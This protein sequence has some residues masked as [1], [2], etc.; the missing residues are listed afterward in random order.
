MLAGRDSARPVPCRTGLRRKKEITTERAWD[1]V[2]GLVEQL[3]HAWASSKG[4]ISR[5][6][7]LIPLRMAVGLPTDTVPKRPDTWITVRKNWACW[8]TPNGETDPDKADVWIAPLDLHGQPE[9]S[10]AI[11][12][13]AVTHWES[14]GWLGRQPS[15]QDLRQLAAQA[16]A[17][18]GTFSREADQPDPLTEGAEKIRAHITSLAEKAEAVDNDHLNVEYEDGARG[19]LGG[20]FGDYAGRFNPDVAGYLSDL[21]V[22][23]AT[24]QSAAA[25]RAIVEKIAAAYNDAATRDQHRTYSY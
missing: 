18:L 1:T 12:L 5:Q 2:R 7:H 6:D 15:E 17:V 11:T 3:C 8:A 24:E 16:I 23:V 4:G 22:A 25:V 9:Y 20:I 21:M 10:S 13:D 14:F 19:G